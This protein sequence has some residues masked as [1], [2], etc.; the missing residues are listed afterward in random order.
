MLFAEVRGRLNLYVIF[1]VII[2]M[3]Q[4]EKVKHVHHVMVIDKYE[5]VFRQYSASWN[6]NVR[7][8]SVLE[9]GKRL[10]KNVSH[11]MVAENSLRK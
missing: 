6:N 4:V 2:V 3:G 9:Q 5:N 10:Q 11:V 1:I 8:A 7:V